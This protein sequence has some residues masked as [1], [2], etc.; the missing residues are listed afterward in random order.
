MGFLDDEELIDDE[1]DTSDIVPEINAE[2]TQLINDPDMSVDLLAK[3]LGTHKGNKVNLIKKKINS[4]F[5]IFSDITLK[6][7]LSIYNSIISLCDK[8]EQIERNKALQGKAVIGIG[9]QFSAGKSY[10]INKISGI[11]TTL[12]TDQ[13]PTTAIPTYIVRADTEKYVI[14]TVDGGSIKTNC[15][16]VQALTHDFDMKY[17]FGFSD[18]VESIFIG[19][20]M[21]S[22]FENIALLDTP[23]YSKNEQ[24]N[25]RN[26]VTDV[27]KAYEQLKSCDF[28]IWVAKMV[29]G[30]TDDDIDFIKSLEINRPILFVLN[31]ADLEMLQSNRVKCLEHTIEQINMSGLPCAGVTLYSAETGK[32]YTSQPE[33]QPFFEMVSKFS[34]S[35]E[36]ILKQ[37]DDLLNRLQDSFDI[38]E[39]NSKKTVDTLRKFVTDSENINAIR[40]IADMWNDLNYE[41]EQ[42]YGQKNRFHIEKGTI[43]NT[44]KRMYSK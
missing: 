38:Y 21:F 7:E 3:V 37:F 20:P 33:I 4:L 34:S 10:F 15:T 13:K 42:I 19:S 14:N 30:I 36:N 18:Y 1:F 22:L 31:Q 8:M 27:K 23:G 2:Y 24:T 29:P 40:T 6:D 12:V 32:E 39:K 16:E 9:G 35:K 25:G 5:D 43:A 26:E 11:G 44:M 17:G 28:L 41:Y